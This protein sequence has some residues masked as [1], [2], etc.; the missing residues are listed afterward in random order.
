MAL[1]KWTI[2]T[3]KY[4]HKQLSLFIILVFENVETCSCKS[5]KVNKY[6]DYLLIIN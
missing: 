3:S 6:V 2:E 5:T 1:Q 4:K